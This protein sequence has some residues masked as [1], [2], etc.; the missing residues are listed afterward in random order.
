MT[1]SAFTQYKSASEEEI[2]DNNQTCAIKPSIPMR[3]RTL[4][5]KTSP[6]SITGT[7]LDTTMLVPMSGVTLSKESM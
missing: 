6:G 3:N 1:T 2:I 4:S 5:H 7:I